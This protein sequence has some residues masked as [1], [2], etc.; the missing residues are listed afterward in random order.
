MKMEP[1]LRSAFEG[2]SRGYRFDGKGGCQVCER[3]YIGERR[4]GSLERYAEKTS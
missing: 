1:T 3:T 2:G 4:E